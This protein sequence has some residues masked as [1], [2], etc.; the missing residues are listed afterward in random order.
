DSVYSIGLQNPIASNWS[1][2]SLK[3]P[4]ARYAHKVIRI[5]R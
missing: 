1:L 3:M 4:R 2:D 5:D